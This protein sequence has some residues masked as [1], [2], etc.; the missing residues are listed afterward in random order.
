M[1]EQGSPPQLYSSK[2]MYPL[3]FLFAIGA[4]HAVVAGYAPSI[5]RKHQAESVDNFL[6]KL[7]HVANDTLFNEMMG[8]SVGADVNHLT[9][10]GKDIMLMVFF[11]SLARR[12][13]HHNPQCLGTSI[14]C[15]VAQ[16]RLSLISHLDQPTHCF[17]VQQ[18][19]QVF[20]HTN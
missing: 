18:G 20:A 19:C 15:V 6:E 3:V 8:A 4:A 10:H 11:Y 1:S 17:S 9:T 12:D 7:H 13:C 16:R 14:H 2:A 5:R